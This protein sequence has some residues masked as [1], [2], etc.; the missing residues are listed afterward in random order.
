MAFEVASVYNHI[1][2]LRGHQVEGIKQSRKCRF[3]HLRQRE[4]RQE[5]GGRQ[6]DAGV[7]YDVSRD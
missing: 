5:M 7:A 1:T 4:A 6:F 2:E 3:R